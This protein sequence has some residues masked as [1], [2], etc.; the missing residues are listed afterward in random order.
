M[1]AIIVIAVAALVLLLVILGFNSLVRS[2]NKTDNAWAQVDVQL[3]KRHDLIPNL[4]E[5]VKGYAA[6]ERQTFEAVTA[7]RTAALNTRGPA[8]QA[9]AENALTAAVGRLMAVAENYPQLRSSANFLALQ[10]QLSSVESGI[11]Y[12]RQYYND[13]VLTYENRRNQFPLLLIA[14]P[15]GFHQRE[16][17]KADAAATEPV[18]TSFT[19]SP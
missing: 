5:T 11:A 18:A 12:A 7:A 9:G 3:T 14:G 16:Y 17:F 2:R 15:L 4:V 13:S 1:L 8:A 6:H 19:A 10:D